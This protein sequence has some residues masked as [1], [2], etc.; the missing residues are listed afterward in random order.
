MKM[1]RLVAT[2]ISGLL[3]GVLKAV[4]A[5]GNSGMFPRWRNLGKSITP[6]HYMQPILI[7]IP[8]EQ[9]RK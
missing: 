8:V 1:I 6:Y 7:P 2:A 5:M 9:K 4:P 3:D